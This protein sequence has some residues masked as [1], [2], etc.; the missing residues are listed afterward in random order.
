[1]G[2]SPFEALYGYTPKHFGIAETDVL[3]SPD[4]S[5][6]LK[7]RQLMTD[8]IKQHLGRAKDRMKKQADKKISE[9]QFEIGD[10][11]FLKLQ[12]YVQSSLAR[13]SNQKLAFKYFG[14][15]KILAHNGSMAYKLELPPTT[16]IHPV[17]HVSQLKKG[18]SSNTSVTPLPDDVSLPRVPEAVL[19]RR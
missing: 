4:L 11:V 10:M 12:P 3:S 8:L 13:R 19:Q 2:R 6:W 15:Y 14:P 5:I 1:V 17:F 9:R 16:A 7:E 18:V